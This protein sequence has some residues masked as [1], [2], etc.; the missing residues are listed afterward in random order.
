LVL[1]F[2]TAMDVPLG[3]DETGYAFVGRGLL[4]DVS[5]ID[6]P[7]YRSI[8]T[9]VL[10]TIP[11]A[12]GENWAFR[13]AATLYTIGT[14]L[15][16]WR[17]S[18]RWLGRHGAALALVAVSTSWIVL[19]RGWELH[20]D[21]PST[22]VLLALAWIILRAHCDSNEPRWS[23][24][25]AAP[26]AA[27][28]F[29]VR[30]GVLLELPALF[31]AAVVTWPRLLKAPA[32][33]LSTLA[34][35]GALLIPHVLYSVHIFGTPWGLLQHA[36]EVHA[37]AWIGRGYWLLLLSLPQ[38]GICFAILLVVGIISGARTVWQR[39][40]RTGTFL[41]TAA[42]S[43]LL[44][45]GAR[46]HAEPRYVLFDL[47]VVAAL[48]AKAM[49]PWCL[50]KTRNMQFMMAAVAVINALAC[51]AGA[52]ISAHGQR[53]DHRGLVEIAHRLQPFGDQCRIV[54]HHAL[55][56]GW[57]TRCKAI[58]IAKPLQCNVPD[59]PPTFIVI[60]D[61]PQAPVPA[62]VTR[63][64]RGATKVEDIPL[65]GPRIKSVTLYR[66]D[67]PLLITPVT[68]PHSR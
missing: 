3:R 28:A 45:I 9:G 29:Y 53:G 17:F 14:M 18:R 63:W 5:R 56:L 68:T 11:A 35:F 54:S 30:Y 22:A 36:R 55:Q 27:T 41:W 10:A 25:W 60:F 31:A 48:G 46:G 2:I 33:L 62:D 67:S 16:F 47:F 51:G 38:L 23:L 59:D 58:N 57:Y 50:S 39:V 64:L 61:E 40:D 44:I 21:L 19:R 7:E 65:P 20:S 15:L 32:K 26:L 13:I 1:S 12:I 24:L 8:G 4:A 43:H 49:A 6:Y 34:I 37:E 42:M 66:C 52:I